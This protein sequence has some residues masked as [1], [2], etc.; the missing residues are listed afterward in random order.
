MKKDV[1]LIRKTYGVAF[2]CISIPIVV[3][4]VPTGDIVFANG[5]TEEIAGYSLAEL[6]KMKV[7]ELFGEEDLER[8]DE[9]VSDYLGI[10][11]GREHEM[12]LKR[13]SSRKLTINLDFQTLTLEGGNYFIITLIDITQLNMHRH[14]V[15]DFGE[16][17]DRHARG[18]EVKLRVEQPPL[19]R[20]VASTRNVLRGVPLHIVRREA[21]HAVVSSS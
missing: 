8:V 4:E 14:L 16:Q 12:Q 17:S 3:A 20:L 7:G 1:A 19:A 11:S 2:D 18:A 9:I 6:E 5:R 10:P 13:K 15:R 21:D